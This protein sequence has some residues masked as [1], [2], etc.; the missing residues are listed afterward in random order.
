MDEAGEKAPLPTTV[1]TGGVGRWYREAPGVAS[2]GHHWNW[3][4]DRQGRELVAGSGCRVQ[5]SASLLARAGE[6]W[7]RR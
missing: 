4:D 7:R 1:Q 2:V 3:K 6:Q 5:G